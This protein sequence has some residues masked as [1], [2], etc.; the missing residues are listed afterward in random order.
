V[1]SSRLA[2]S[3]GDHFWSGAID[4]SVIAVSNNNSSPYYFDD[5]GQPCALP[6]SGLG[7]AANW[8]ATLR[9]WYTDTDGPTAA[10][11]LL[12]VDASAPEGV[13]DDSQMTFAWT[14]GG[15]SHSG[16]SQVLRLERAS[17]EASCEH[18]LAPADDSFSFVV[19]SPLPCDAGGTLAGSTMPLVEGESYLATVR[20]SNGV[21]PVIENPSTVDSVP[22]QPILQQALA[23]LIFQDGFESGATG[24][25]S[26][27][28][29]G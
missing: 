2:E 20:T 8:H 26:S 19:G 3:L 24:A 6:P 28:S 14:V 27:S 29:D 7:S 12:H 23:T 4:A 9:S 1:S 5:D 25:W 22:T 21:D 10:S 15:D 17:D 11:A 13:N 18:E 16:S